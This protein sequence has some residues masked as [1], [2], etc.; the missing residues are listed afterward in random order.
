VTLAS[1]LTLVDDMIRHGKDG[2]ILAQA[3]VDT[4]PEPLIVLGWNL[5]VV[6]ASRSF[7]QLGMFE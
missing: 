6:A 2:H 7:Y 1:N 5:H 4:V 3:I